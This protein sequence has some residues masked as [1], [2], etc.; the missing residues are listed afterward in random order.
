VHADN[1]AA[2]PRAVWNLYLIDAP[3]IS[4]A[5]VAILSASEAAVERTFSAQ[6][7]VHT[8]LRNRLGDATVEA[9]MFI[10][11]NQRTVAG[12]EGQ[13]P[14]V[15]RKTHSPGD[16]MRY[17]AE[18]KEEYEEDP[19]L[20]PVVG[21][22][23]RPPPEAKAEEAAAV[24]M[25]AEEEKAE[26]APAPLAVISQV[27]RPP[28]R[29]NMQAFIEHIVTLMGVT[30]K[31]RWLEAK[32]IQLW[33]EGQKWRPPMEDMDVVLKNKV[34]AWVRAQEQGAAEV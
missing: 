10:K 29:D 33:D 11:F 23:T 24:A 28:A 19:N 1:L 16:A 34:M 25:E 13:Q 4:H 3:I 20:P 26:F 30:S 9:E 2:F 17:C 27:P 6:G 31:F 32:M 7:L 14:R 21:L 12:V 15:R 18:M 5:A 22:F 8:D